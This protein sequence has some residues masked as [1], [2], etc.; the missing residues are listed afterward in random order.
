MV[1]GAGLSGLRTVERLRR[2]GHTGPITLVG[3]EQHLPYDR[4]PLSKSFLTA[5]ETPEAPLLR[6]R[7][8]FADLDCDLRLGVS[9]ARLD[10]TEHTLTLSDGAVLAWDDLVL[11]TG[12]Q[13]RL[14]PALGTAAATLRT[15]EDAT[16]LRAH[17]RQASH[18]TVVGA[19]VLGCEVASAAR[20]LEIQVALV[21]LEPAPLHRVLGSELGGLAA[22]LHRQHG[23][24]LHCGLSVSATDPLA[25]GHLVTLSDGT[26]LETD[27]VVVTVGS[28][29]DTAWLEGSGL[30]LDDG[31]VCD[32]SG[33][34]TVPGIWAVGDV[35]RVRAPG[36]ARGTRSEHWTAAG[37]AAALVAANITR[38][39][40]ERR[41]SSEVPY[42]WSDQHGVKI[43]GLGHPA[44]EHEVTYVE[45]GPDE[46]SFLA[47][48]H[49]RGTVRAAVGFAQPAALARC[50]TLVERSMPL[51]EAL[52]TRPWQPRRKASA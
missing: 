9:A 44:A 32:Q 39:P 25:G 45:G 47:L 42:F 27:L 15:L 3:A 29:V 22:D 1:V 16:S 49:D 31:V 51:D 40:A 14:L 6:A 38:S 52:E 43:Q 37:D 24:D 13:A 2:S 35:A 23:V 33:A 19:G 50:R 7:E 26:R 21:D 10:A 4:P 8:S 5:E 30:T 28:Q 41:S 34:T 12:S 17:L 46:G 18:V 11:A 36:E 20:A 48:L